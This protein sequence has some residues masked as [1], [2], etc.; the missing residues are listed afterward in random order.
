M[1][2]RISLFFAKRKLQNILSE[3]QYA[4][5]SIE[6]WNGKLGALNQAKS[7]AEFNL[8]K[9]EAP[10]DIQS[11]PILPGKEQS[12]MMMNANFEDCYVIDTI[13]WPN[14]SCFNNYYPR[15]EQRPDVESDKF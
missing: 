10:I 5:A 11:L 12:H 6:F 2:K 1:I 7:D 8:A 14:G 4:Q 13:S 3:I 15:F 9:F